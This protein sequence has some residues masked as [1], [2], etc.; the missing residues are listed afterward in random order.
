V[1]CTIAAARSCQVGKQPE[2]RS[3]PAGADEH[4]PGHHQQQYHQSELSVQ[5]QDELPV[6]SE[7]NC[8]RTTAIAS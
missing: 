4:E 6:S 7:R 8:V 2:C 1:A 5:R 3:D